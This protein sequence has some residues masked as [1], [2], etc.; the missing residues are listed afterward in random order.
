[1]RAKAGSA[2]G[3]NVA[4]RTVWRLT[5][6]LGLGLELRYSFASVEMEVEAEGMDPVA[7]D[8]GGLGVQALLRLQF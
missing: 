1:V 4:G 3:F 2:V 8:A 6:L 5:E 7:V